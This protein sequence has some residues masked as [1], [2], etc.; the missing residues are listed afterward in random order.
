LIGLIK[1]HGDWV[2]E[3]IGDWGFK[4]VGFEMLEW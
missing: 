4:R 1:E 3:K 2:E